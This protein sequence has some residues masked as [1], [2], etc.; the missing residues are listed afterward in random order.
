MKKNK[1]N[2]MEIKAKY[3]K[4][5]LLNFYLKNNE[6]V[7]IN[8]IYN[9]LFDTFNIIFK[10]EDINETF[11]IFALFESKSIVD[12]IIFNIYEMRGKRNANNKRK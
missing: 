7:E 5:R 9:S 3:I 6:K 4:K 11:T 2:N 1:K 8:V 10:S 12:T